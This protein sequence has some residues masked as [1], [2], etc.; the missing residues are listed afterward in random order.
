M[1]AATLAEMVKAET[2]HAA[3]LGLGDVLSERHRVVSEW[4][5][6]RENHG[7]TSGRLLELSEVLCVGENSLHGEKFADSS[8]AGNLHI[9]FEIVPSPIGLG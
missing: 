7:R 9:Y 8:I 2:E 5:L 4:N 6:P 3:V 1:I